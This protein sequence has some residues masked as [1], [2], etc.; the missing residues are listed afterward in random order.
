VKSPIDHIVAEAAGWPEIRSLLAHIAPETIQAAYGLGGSVKTLLVAAIHR[1]RGK[2]SLY[3]AGDLDAARRAE[4]DFVTWLGEETV[5]LLPPREFSPLGVVAQ[6]GEIQAQRLRVL[7]ALL[8][9]RP[10]LVVL[11]VEAAMG[12]VPSPGR[13]QRHSCSVGVGL[14]LEPHNLAEFLVTAGYE[15]RAQVENPGD[16]SLRGG[17]VDV[18]PPSCQEPMR[19][20][21]QDD[22]ITSIR[23]FSLLSQ[24]SLSSLERASLSPAREWVFDP[25]ETGDLARE[26]RREMN[27]A[28]KSLEKVGRR[29]AASRLEAKIAAD[30]DHMEAGT[31]LED[32]HTYAPL[33]EPSIPLVFDFLPAAATVFLD[34]PL[35]LEQ[36]ARSAGLEQ[37]E[38]FSALVAG[39]GLLPALVN[40]GANY[41]QALTRARRQATI[42]LAQ[43][44]RRD[45]SA[46]TVNIVTVRHELIP[47][48]HGQWQD[49]CEEL[50]RW[51]RSGDRCLLLAASADGVDGV[52]R[53]LR[54]ADFAP[55]TG[56]TAERTAGQVV[57]GR[58]VL[59]GGFYLPGP[60]LRV[61]T[62]AQ[63]RGR[64]AK[65][66][67][68]TSSAAGGGA[69]RALAS[70]RELDV[71]DFVVHINHGI[72]VYL[73]VERREDRYLGVRDCIGIAYAGADRLYVPADQVGL[74]QKYVGTEGRTPEVHGLGGTEWNRAKTRARESLLKLAVDLVKLYAQRQALPGHSFAPDAIWQAEFEAGF[75]Y[76]ETPDQLIAV[77]E[78]KRDMERPAPMDRLLCGDVGYGKTEVAVRAAF[79]AVMGGKQAA[80]LVPT[81]VLAQQHYHTFRERFDGYPVNTDLLSRFRS[82]ARQDKT[83]RDIR[84]GLVDIVI[85][86]HRLLAADVVFKDLGLL[87]IDE[88][89]RFGVG[90]KERLKELK[91]SV[92]VLVLTATPIPRTLNMA[93]VGLRD[94]SV[95]DTP[96]E[97]RLPVQT[98][99][100]EY[101]EDL[102]KDAVLR[103]MARGGQVFYVHN[104]VQ[105][106][107]AVAAR[108]QALAPKARVVVA[109]GQ[110]KEDE[111]ERTMFDF[112]EGEHDVLVSTTIIESGLDLPNVNT[113]IV[114]DADT[115]GLAQLYQL[116]GRVGRSN[117]V[118]YAY[119]TYRPGRVISEQ[120]EKR[121]EA[122]HEFTELGSGYKIA[123]RDLEIR[124]AGN[125]LG[126]EQHGFIASVGFELYCRML[127]EAVRQLKGEPEAARMDAVVDVKVDAYLPDQ[128]IPNARQKMEIYHRLADAAEP[129]EISDLQEEL[130]DRYGTPPPPV[131]ILL[132]VAKL[133]AVGG[134]LGCAVISSDPAGGLLA[135]FDHPSPATKAALSGLVGKYPGISA[136]I[137]PRATLLGYRPGRRTSLGD[138]KTGL[139]SD[140]VELV[141]GLLDLMLLV[142]GRLAQAGG[143]SS[144]V[145]SR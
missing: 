115:L 11:P 54:E 109:H 26:V 37:S 65:R 25:A 45:S 3:V 60:R 113:L 1:A 8:A 104:R 12:L 13:L 102:V 74:L 112:L 83:V 39:G 105:S 18:L 133:K 144:D 47:S 70:Y 139:L 51:R 61:V 110:M 138:R 142:R 24:K 69:T 63:I 92:D 123:L 114:E 29:E 52:T 119:F 91:T 30:I 21:F 2:P 20:E 72:G 77:E 15:R 27:E 36:A 128:Y 101:D 59:E 19:L 118:A 76:E 31:L 49:F 132:A 134:S 135:R 95:I 28:A 9:G 73:G 120:A 4:S 58:G 86:T 106:I 48:F 10:I 107:E 89:H 125:L 64:T 88:E 62:D 103:E 46:G 127:E 43:L 131:A 41:D 137:G 108:L 6:S 124:G 82:R 17:I 85:G 87:I 143:E 38:R 130:S 50:G 94:M 122:I 44:P 67:R 80:V 22:R 136:R 97:D 111:L 57:V 116:R 99:V 66:R 56:L 16:F 14:T 42:R 100:V 121:L 35:R 84:R 32:A 40:W 53:S 78:I 141:R 126:A 96:P 33:I 75:R 71:G 93:L 23:T 7:D 79:K 117:R 90:H 140:N 98:Y 55:A 5:V 145:K 81:T 68:R 34:E 129:E